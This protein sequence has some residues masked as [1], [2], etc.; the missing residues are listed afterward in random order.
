[1]IL[2]QIQLVQIIVLAYLLQWCSHS[3]YSRKCAV[4]SYAVKTVS[5]LII[6]H[7]ALQAKTHHLDT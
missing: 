2:I 4:I 1:M 7:A 3:G 6:L 5:Y